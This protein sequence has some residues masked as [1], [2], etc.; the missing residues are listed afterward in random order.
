M[1]Y[2]LKKTNRDIRKNQDQK[3]DLI[4][5]LEEKHPLKEND[6]K[7]INKLISYKDQR[8]E[9][10]RKE[11]NLDGNKSLTVVGL[12][13]LSTVLSVALNKEGA[14]AILKYFDENRD[15]VTNAAG[16]AG[17]LVSIGLFLYAA[18]KLTEK[19]FSKKSKRLESEKVFVDNMMNFD[20]LSDRVEKI[21]T[22]H[23][24]QSPVI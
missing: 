12:F 9:L 4:N 3:N 22:D 24:G 19:C 18:E 10:G 11:R 8:I 20:D 1:R 16:M 13:V 2:I 5:F 21:M 14:K 7:D 23:R 17:F 6:I 15:F